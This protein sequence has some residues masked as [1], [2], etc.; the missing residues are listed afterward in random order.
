MTQFA[1]TATETIAR[2]P[3]P[4]PDPRELE[5]THRMEP[6]PDTRNERLRTRIEVR[7]FMPSGMPVGYENW[8]VEVWELKTPGSS[9]EFW[10]L[11]HL[12]RI[13]YTVV[14][15]KAPKV[16]LT[17]KMFPLLRLARV[18]A[19]QSADLLRC[20]HKTGQWTRTD[21]GDQR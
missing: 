12:T 3:D 10:V 13:D 6:D 7:S 14:Q 20:H 15:G 18:A 1:F 5:C 4:N 17:P 8:H 16:R 21:Y 2:G 11:A 19:A 9:K